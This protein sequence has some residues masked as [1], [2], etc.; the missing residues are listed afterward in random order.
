MTVY[1]DMYK[2]KPLA[3]IQQHYASRSVNLA[4]HVNCYGV[5]IYDHSKYLKIVSLPDSISMLCKTCI[6]RADWYCIINSN[7]F[8]WLWSEKIPEFNLIC[9]LKCLQERLATIFMKNT[10][11]TCIMIFGQPTNLLM[12]IL[13]E[14]LVSRDMSQMICTAFA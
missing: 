8:Y 5:F 3:N 12:H 9:Y 11:W 13:A 6:F 4:E 2:M 7:W 14:I 1:V 10:C